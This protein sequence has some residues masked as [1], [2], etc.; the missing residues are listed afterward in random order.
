MP[1]DISVVVP[2]YVAH[3]KY[4]NVIFDDIRNQTVLPKEI[5]LAVSEIDDNI[6]N[7]ILAQ[8]YELFQTKN[9]GFEIVHTSSK[10]LPGENR[11][12]GAGIA[13]A[14]Y[15]MFID[16]DDTIHPK[17]IEATV[18]FLEFYKPNLLVH[19]FVKSKPIDYLKFLDIDYKNSPVISN[20]EIYTDTFG[21]PPYRNRET[22]LQ[23]KHKHGIGLK[24]KKRKRQK[25]LAVTHGYATV[26]RSLFNNFSYTNLE[27]GEDGV[28]IRDILWNV[29]G[30]MYICIPLLNYEPIR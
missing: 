11:N 6:K 26:K 1:I 10:R 24:S 15:V 18:Y 30:V 22:E 16:A 3:I 4:L 21:F 19:S 9:I 27:S 7:D 5:I 2:C 14:E 13:S 17:K 29:G 28:F 23:S 8:Y 25:Y 20:N 12:V